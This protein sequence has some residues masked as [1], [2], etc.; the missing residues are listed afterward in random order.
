MVWS[1]HHLCCFITL[2][3]DFLPHTVHDYHVCVCVTG[4]Y[5]SPLRNH[6]AAFNP[7]PAVH[8]QLTFINVLQFML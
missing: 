1:L 3:Y 4:V 5:L 6:N 8:V 7:C 2:D